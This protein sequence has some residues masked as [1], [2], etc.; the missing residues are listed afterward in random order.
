MTFQG[1]QMNSD[2]YVYYSADLVVFLKSPPLSSSPVSFAKTS[3]LLW[4][5]AWNIYSQI[6]S[7]GC[8]T[9]AGNCLGWGCAKW[10]KWASCLKCPSLLFWKWTRSQFQTAGGTTQFEHHP[11]N[12]WSQ[13]LMWSLSLK[14]YGKSLAKLGLLI[15]LQSIM[16]EC[17]FWMQGSKKW[18][19]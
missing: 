18:G 3:P 14:I 16:P 15:F 8:F 13:Q 9:L 17:C 5:M 2:Y 4:V 12:V 6:L 19:R 11:A 1:H 7:T 10:A